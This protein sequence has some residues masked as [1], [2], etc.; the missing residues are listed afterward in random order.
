MNYRTIMKEIAV[1]ITCHN[2]KEKTLACLAALYKCAIPQGYVFSVFLVD[3]GCTDYTA[4]AV[5][6]KFPAV[7][8]IKGN[9]KLYWNRG[10]RLAWSTAAI[11]GFDYYLWLNDDTSLFK[12]GL[13]D[14][15]AV[16]EN[17]GN[18]IIVCGVTQSILSDTITYS[19]FKNR[20]MVMPNGEI[21]ACDSFN[22]NIVLI[23]NVVYQK[24]GN[25]D[26]KFSH[27]IGDLDYGLR[28]KKKGIDI[29]ITTKAIAYCENNPQLPLWCRPEKPFL[30]RLK[31][32]YS[33]LGYSTPLEYFVYKR[34]HF[35]I[36]IAIQHF[37]TIHL[38]LLF[39]KLWKS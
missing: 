24:V 8:I 9:G 15:L 20:M 23:P 26:N 31:F 27:S 12:D 35:G 13:I 34:R 18:D 16:I 22:G 36:L 29:Y 33:P 37:F 25:L 6:E 10:M 7:T 14:L 21:Q 30:T 5:S 1:L 17:K 2:R 32:L 11:K 38:R 4:K 3:D 19:G 39:P 28:A